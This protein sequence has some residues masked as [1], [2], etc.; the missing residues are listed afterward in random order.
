MNVDIPDF[1][2]VPYDFQVYQA[3]EDL[4]ETGVRLGVMIEAAPAGHG[5]VVKGVAARFQ[6]RTGRPATGGSAPLPRRRALD[7]EF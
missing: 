1:P 6:R 5:L 4:P 7:G 3:Y 2:M